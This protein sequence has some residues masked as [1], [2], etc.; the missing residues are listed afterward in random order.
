[1]EL[2]Q[3]LAKATKQPSWQSTLE[4]FTDGNDDF[5]SYVLP[6][7]FSLGLVDYGQLVKVKEPGVWY[8]KSGW[9]FMALLFWV[10]LRRRMLRISTGFCVS[11]LEGWLG[12]RSVLRRLKDGWFSQLIS[13]SF[14]VIS[15]RSL[16]RVNRQG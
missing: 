8:A 10:I 13:F 12:G 7:C 4:L 6:R 14:T 3:K 15:L 16:R 5:Y 2:M 9:W 1:M 11:G